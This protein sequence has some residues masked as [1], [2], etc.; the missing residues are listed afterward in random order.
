MWLTTPAPLFKLDE[1]LTIFDARATPKSSFGQLAFLQVGRIC[2]FEDHTGHFRMTWARVAEVAG[3]GKRPLIACRESD[4]RS[5]HRLARAVWF[6]IQ[7]LKPLNR[8]AF[9]P[10][11]YGAF[12]LP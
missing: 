5:K 1:S 2:A 7:L 6:Q 11:V 8:K 9:S 4:L 3:I 12:L 10:R